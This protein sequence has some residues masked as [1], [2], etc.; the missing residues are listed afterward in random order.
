MLRNLAVYNDMGT[1]ANP[2]SPPTSNPISNSSQEWDGEGLGKDQMMGRGLG[3]PLHPNKE[4]EKG[5]GFFVVPTR[6]GKGLGRLKITEGAGLDC[7]CCLLEIGIEIRYT[8]I[9]SHIFS[10]FLCDMK[11]TECQLV[12]MTCFAPWR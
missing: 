5:F 7:T 10:F 6:G 8:H 4:A 9:I 11:S 3:G 1:L 12:H 2:L